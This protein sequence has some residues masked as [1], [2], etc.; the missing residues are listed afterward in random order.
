MVGLK[1][2]ILVRAELLELSLEELILVIG[3]GLLVQN[4]DI[5][6]IIALNL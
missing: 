5:R 2:A 1:K 6:Y 4:E 3:D